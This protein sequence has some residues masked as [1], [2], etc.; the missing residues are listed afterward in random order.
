MLLF[1]SVT[2]NIHHEYHKPNVTI[3][4]FCNRQHSPWVSQA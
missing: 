4:C 3:D 1:V 2:D